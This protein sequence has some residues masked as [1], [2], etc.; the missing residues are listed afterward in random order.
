MNMSIICIIHNHIRP[1][2]NNNQHHLQ[3]KIIIIVIL[4]QRILGALH[5]LV[6]MSWI[7]CPVNSKQKETLLWHAEYKQLFESTTNGS[8]QYT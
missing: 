6:R 4:E 8:D 2:N 7:Y 1:N 3:Q 5:Y